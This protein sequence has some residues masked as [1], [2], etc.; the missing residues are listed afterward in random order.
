ML[1]SVPDF[2]HQRDI[3]LCAAGLVVT[4]HATAAGIMHFGRLFSA[5]LLVWMTIL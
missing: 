3:E 5:L 4:N 2:V 1:F